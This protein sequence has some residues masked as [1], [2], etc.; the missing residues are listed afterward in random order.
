MGRDRRDRLVPILRDA[1]IC[2]PEAEVRTVP[3]GV[4]R[5]RAAGPYPDGTQSLPSTAL[6]Q[7]A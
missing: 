3:T 7:Y 6:H 5:C 2:R 1:A 4:F